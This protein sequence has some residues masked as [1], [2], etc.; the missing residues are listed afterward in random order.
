MPTSC[1][2]VTSVFR[3]STRSS[4]SATAA[5][6]RPGSR[7][8]SSAGRGAQSHRELSPSEQSIDIAGG[9]RRRGTSRTGVARR[10]NT[11]TS[12]SNDETSPGRVDPEPYE[13]GWIRACPSRSATTRW[14]RR[15]RSRT[16]PTSFRSAPRC[17]PIPRCPTGTGSSPRAST[18]PDLVP[19]SDAG[20]SVAASTSSAGAG[21][22]TAAASRSPGSST[23]TACM[24][25]SDAAQEALARDRR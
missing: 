12:T 1:R 3:C 5:P 6:S 10:G 24:L 4:A 19:P 13:L 17:A 7:G 25:A 9:Q 2:R 20:R 22:P 16:A 11:T 14:C 23:A 18:T 8:V 21:W 15:V